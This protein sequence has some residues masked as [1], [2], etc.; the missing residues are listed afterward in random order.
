MNGQS[1]RWGNISAGVL[2]GSILGPLF[3][4]I[5]INDLTE[6]LSCSVKLFADDTSLFTTVQDPS[7][8]ASDLNHDLDLIRLWAHKWRMSFNPDPRKQAVELVF[9]K[10]TAKTDHPPVFFNDAPVMNVDQHKHLGVIL[11]PKLS[12]SA[13]IQAA[14]SKSRK[15]IGMLRFLSKIP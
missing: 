8:A 2:Q 12:F 3:F 11:D 10:K 15:A 5:Y 6:N 1:S 9:S 13:H 4:L 7:S 14:I